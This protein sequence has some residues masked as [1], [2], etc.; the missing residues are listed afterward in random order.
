MR[1][2]SRGSEV[3]ISEG[4]SI[5]ASVAVDVI[6]CAAMTADQ[7]ISVPKRVPRQP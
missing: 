5:N 6:V 4:P 3:Q 2:L 7:S 1:I